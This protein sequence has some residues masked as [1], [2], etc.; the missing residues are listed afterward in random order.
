MRV[1]L[2]RRSLLAWTLHISVCVPGTCSQVAARYLLTTKCD[3]YTASRP[4]DSNISVFTESF[5]DRKRQ[6]IDCCRPSG[7]GDDNPSAKVRRSTGC[8]SNRIRQDGLSPD[9]P[10]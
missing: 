2:L 5:L 9:R 10:P 6:I 4:R 1:P 8:E 3:S 7:S